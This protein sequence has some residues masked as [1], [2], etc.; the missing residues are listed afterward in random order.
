[1]HVKSGLEYG[2]HAYL[3]S[4][5]P[6]STIQVDI[7]VLTLKFGL[8]GHR[9]VTKFIH[10]PNTVG[11]GKKT[12]ITSNW[13]FYST[14]FY[15]ENLFSNSSLTTLI[16]INDMQC[17]QYFFQTIKGNLKISKHI[18]THKLSIIGV[19]VHGLWVSL[20]RGIDFIRWYM[21]G[22]AIRACKVWRCELRHYPTT[23]Q[24]II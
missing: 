14:Q 8:W 16:P 4:H 19:D 1:M 21:G 13:Q 20:N 12:L 15:N 9:H 2:H 5:H 6:S 22:H 23:S 17:T 11:E 10:K 18:L 3:T 24:E 7:L